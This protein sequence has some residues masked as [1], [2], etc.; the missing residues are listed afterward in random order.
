M[1][2]NISSIVI[3]KVGNGYIVTVPD[4]TSTHPMVELQKQISEDLL[5]KVQYLMLFQGKKL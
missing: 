3:E 1:K 2:A 5:R 4:E